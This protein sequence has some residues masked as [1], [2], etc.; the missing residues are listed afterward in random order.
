MLLRALGEEG[1]WLEFRHM[2]SYLILY[3]SHYLCEDLLHMASYLIL[4]SSHHM[5]E[6]LLHMASYLI[7]YISQHLC[8]DLLHQV[9]LCLGYFT[10]LHPDNQVVLQQLCSLPFQYFSDPHLTAVLFPS[11]ISCC[12]NNHSNRRILQQELSCVLLA[13]FIEVGHHAA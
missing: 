3:S 1:M 12:S 9:I 10:L 4:Y 5:C 13:N 7:L 6:D 8:E 11:L 2:A